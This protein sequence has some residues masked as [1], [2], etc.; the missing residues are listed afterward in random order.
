[1]FSAN[2]V[3]IQGSVNQLPFGGVG[4]SGNG[5]ASRG[6]RDF[7]SFSYERSI[8]RSSRSS[9]LMEMLLAV[10]YPPA[11]TFKLLLS[12]VAGSRQ[13]WFDSQGRTFLL[14]RITACFSWLGRQSMR[15]LRLIGLILAIV[16]EVPQTLARVPPVLSRLWN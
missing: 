3:M 12:Q 5:A 15:V 13:P 2:D 14:A 8:I 7:T 16:V 9:S 6:K 11:T 1:M 10:R 4:T